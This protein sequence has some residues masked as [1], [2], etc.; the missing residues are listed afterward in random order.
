MAPHDKKYL[1]METFSSPQGLKTAPSQRESR[2]ACLKVPLD[3][4]ASGHRADKTPANRD[5]SPTGRLTF[6]PATEEGARRLHEA[7][8]ELDAERT[9][10]EAEPNA[11]VAPAGERA[12]TPI[13]PARTSQEVAAELAE[14]KAYEETWS[15]AARRRRKAELERELDE[16]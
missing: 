3:D 9:R 2:N 1:Q 5:F 10:L 7:E 4:A 15:A 16:A 14:L 8:Q 11:R 12:L 13:T 6:A